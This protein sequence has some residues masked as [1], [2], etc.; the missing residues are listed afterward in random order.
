[1]TPAQI[2]ALVATA[3]EILRIALAAKKASE[4]TAEWNEAD[5]I[6]FVKKINEARVSPAWQLE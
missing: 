4:Q 1:M 5:E 6:A 2:I 3:G